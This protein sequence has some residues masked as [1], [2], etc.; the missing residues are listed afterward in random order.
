MDRVARGRLGWE[1]APIARNAVVIFGG[2]ALTTLS[3][4]IQIPFW[5]VPMTLQTMAVMALAVGLGPRRAVAIFLAYL[6]AGATGAPVFAGSPERG[7]GLV[8][9]AGPTGGY[10]AGYLVAAWLVGTLSAGRGA[11]G[12]AGAMIAGLVPVYAIG[13]LWLSLHVPADRLVAVGVLPFLLGDLVNIALVV[14]TSLAVPACLA[15]FQGTGG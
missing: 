12:R 5:P 15:R 13:L 9:M 11:M 8:Y 3:A 14:A 10:L 4:K 2:V 7:V 6:A 1:A